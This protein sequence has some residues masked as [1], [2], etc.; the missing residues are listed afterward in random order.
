MSGDEDPVVEAVYEFE[1]LLLKFLIKKLNF[2][3]SDADIV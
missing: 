2:R 3:T 1:E